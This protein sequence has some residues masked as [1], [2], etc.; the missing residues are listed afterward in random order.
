M[1]KEDIE[2]CCMVEDWNCESPANVEGPVAL[3][4]RCYVCGQKVCKNCSFVLPEIYRHRKIRA[5]FNCIENDL[6]R[7]NLT[8]KTFLDMLRDRK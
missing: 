5:C 1:K 8:E 2:T 6:K 3:R 4:T 7:F